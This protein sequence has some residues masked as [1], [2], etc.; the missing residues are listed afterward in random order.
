MEEMVENALRSLH[1]FIGAPDFAHEL[2][3]A[4]DEFFKMVGA[5]LSGE[6][7]E[8]MRLSSFTEWF[9]FDR[10]LVASKRTPVE[11][12]LRLHEGELSGGELEVLS[13]FA[14]TL[15]SVFM[16][17]KRSGQ[18]VD[19]KDLY[20]GTKYKAVKRVPVTLGKKDMAELRLAPAGDTWFATDA[21]C[22][23][24]FSAGKEIRKM[25]K[26]ARKK[27][28]PIEPVLMELMAMNTRHE[29][30]RKTTKRNAY[31]SRGAVA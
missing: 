10:Q 9:I 25:L 20:T 6:P 26:Q 13:G 22:Y 3:S 8:E 16:I 14:R 24:P 11:E 27:G 18:A 7:I 31:A 15:H 2:G 19:L 17:K 1:E 5:P 4:K 30:Y 28:E 23:H 12:Y 21:L 29:R